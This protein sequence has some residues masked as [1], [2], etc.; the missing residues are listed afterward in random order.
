[1]FQLKI[2]NTPPYQT[3]N[4][5]IT[6]SKNGMPQK[7]I[8]S[9]GDSSFAM[10]RYDFKRMYSSTQQSINTNKKWFG[11]RDA[12]QI[13]AN[14]RINAIGQ[15]SHNST[16]KP[17][18][19]ETKDDINVRSDALRR[20]RNSGYVTTP[21]VRANPNNAP[22]PSWPVAPLI[23]TSHRA[24]VAQLNFPLWKSKGTRICDVALS[25][26]CQNEAVYPTPP[27]YH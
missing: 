7:D 1:M 14:R 23:R 22:T 25:G 11:N 17:M 16:G 21:K 19:F 12:S 2:T 8:T 18:A 4:N 5:G 15:G 20:V 24:P 10:G 3:I 27:I 6:Y 26:Q 9:D 13:A